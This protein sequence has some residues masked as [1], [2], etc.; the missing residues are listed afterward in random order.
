[1]EMDKQ[2]KETIADT[3]EE[4]LEVFV[5]SAPRELAK[6]DI[7]LVAGGVRGHWDPNG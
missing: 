1:M 6:D 4:K 7:E 3:D 5:R 2:P